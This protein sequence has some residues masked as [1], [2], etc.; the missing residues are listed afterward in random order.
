MMLDPFYGLFN[1]G[2]RIA[3]ILNRI[4]LVFEIYSVFILS[5]SLLK[6]YTI[7]PWQLIPV[8]AASAVC[9]HLANV[10]IRAIWN[11]VIVIIHGTTDADV[12]LEAREKRLSKRQIR[13]A[14]KGQSR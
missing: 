8:I 10:C 5:A 12:I 3:K 1:P 14:A 4:L 6:D 13:Q 7:E 9:I 2:I 11:F